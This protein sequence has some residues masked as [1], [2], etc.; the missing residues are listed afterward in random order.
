L[1]STLG[2][3]VAYNINFVANQ[4]LQCSLQHDL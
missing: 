3:F 4:F 1:F 2:A